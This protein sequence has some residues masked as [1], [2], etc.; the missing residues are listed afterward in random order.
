MTM[1]IVFVGENEQL[2][3]GLGLE[4][5]IVRCDY[6]VYSEWLLWL[7]VLSQSSEEGILLLRYNEMQYIKGIL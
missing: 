7:L 4:T 3:G 6:A 5:S 2:F 1:I